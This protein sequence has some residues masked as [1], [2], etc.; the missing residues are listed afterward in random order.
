MWGGSVC[1]ALYVSVTDYFKPSQLFP[2]GRWHQYGVTVPDVNQRCLYVSLKLE[3]KGKY[4][5]KLWNPGDQ[6]QCWFSGAFL[7]SCYKI[8]LKQ[9][10]V[11][12]GWYWLS[13]RPITI[14]CKN[15]SRTIVIFAYL[16]DVGGGEQH[17]ACVL[18]QI[19]GAA[20]EKVSSQR[21]VERHTLFCKREEWC[22]C[23]AK[24]SCF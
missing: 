3:G 11:F 12:Q 22:A 2:G 17:S 24:N 18:A 10:I 9:Y 15:E 16:V 7:P 19:C 6:I 1:Q 4:K 14:F 20:M 23:R 8:G 21:I 13:R 5:M